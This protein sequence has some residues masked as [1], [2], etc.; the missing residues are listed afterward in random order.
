MCGPVHDMNVM[1]WAWRALSRLRLEMP[2][3]GVEVL[4]K[5]P[6][7]R[8]SRRSGAALLCVLRLR[9]AT[10]LE[11][12]LLRQ[13]WLRQLG[14]E[15]ELVIGVRREEAQFGAHAWLDG[16]NDADGFF[17]LC[18]LSG[19]SAEASCGGHRFSQPNPESDRGRD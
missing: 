3:L 4:V 1:V 14:V 7:V 19:K 11:Q 5:A 12:S 8:K 18:R 13:R 16:D 17:E 2:T 10:C 9:R 6:P 15:R